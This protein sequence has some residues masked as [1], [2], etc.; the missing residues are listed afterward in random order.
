MG[1]VLGHGEV[2]ILYKDKAAFDKK[3]AA[4]VAAGIDQLQVISD[5]DRTL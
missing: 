5:F 2:Q 4:L 1:E 3:R